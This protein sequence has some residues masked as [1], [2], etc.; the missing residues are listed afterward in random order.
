MR[1][2]DLLEKRR[3]H[4]KCTLRISRGFRGPLKPTYGLPGE[5]LDEWLPR[6][7]SQYS[8]GGLADVEKVLVTAG[9]GFS[10]SREVLTLQL[11]TEMRTRR[12]MCVS[13]HST[14]SLG[15]VNMGARVAAFQRTRGHFKSLILNSLVLSQGQFL[16]GK[17]VSQDSTFMPYSLPCSTWIAQDTQAGC[18]CRVWPAAE[19]SEW[20]GAICHPSAGAGDPARLLLEVKGFRQHVTCLLLS[21]TCRLS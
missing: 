18:E 8:W 9:V 11:M 21:V 3:V 17:S 15:Q 5:A 19:C 1:T 14:G 20:G 2:K 12:L 7:G 13:F 10:C 4:R 6:R 16:L